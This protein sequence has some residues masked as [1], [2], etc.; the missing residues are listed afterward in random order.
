VD[1]L[2]RGSQK[3]IDSLRAI[4]AAD[5]PKK[6]SDNTL[7][8][9][10]FFK[11]DLGDEL[12][13]QSLVTKASL[14]SQTTVVTNSKYSVDN[15]TTSSLD[16]VFH[17]AGNSFVR[18]SVLCPANYYRNITQN[19]GILLQAVKKTMNRMP[20]NTF[21]S[22]S[23]QL[24]VYF[25]FASSCSVYGTQPPVPVTEQTR[26]APGS[27]YAQ[28]KVASER[29][30]RRAVDDFQ[31]S[32]DQ[33]LRVRVFR[34]FNVIGAD[35]GGRLGERPRPELRK[36]SRLWTACR[37]VARG[38]SLKPYVEVHGV[39]GGSN[40]TRDATPERDFVHVADITAGIRQAWLVDAGNHPSKL[41][42]FEVFNLGTGHPVSVL[43]FVEAC[44]RATGK[45]IPVRVVK[46]TENTGPKTSAIAVWSD[47]SKAKRELDWTPRFST[48]LTQALL[49]AWRFTL[50]HNSY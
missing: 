30:L 26:L 32:N 33:N 18:E 19:T 20:A 36:Y 50:R 44:R 10:R 25:Y 41:Q 34:F 43:E 15:R 40:V 4:L 16:S 1:N 35:P 13:L 12:Q 23:T 47:I 29:I 6:K 48:N 2:S 7:T 39:D 31:K 14:A 45:K 49:E 5:L 37:D 11:M 9:I 3:A 38:F 21:N 24:P 42:G 8:K 46:T 27:P 28:A 17:F 22:S